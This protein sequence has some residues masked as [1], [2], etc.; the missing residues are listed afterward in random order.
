MK[1]V[2]KIKTHIFVQKLFSE[3]RAVFEIVKKYGEAR[4]ATDNNILRRMRCACQDTQHLIL[5]AS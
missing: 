4:E 5:I 1:V 3:N 2:E